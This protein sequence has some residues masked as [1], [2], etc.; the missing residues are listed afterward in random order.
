MP[1]KYSVLSVTTLGSLMAAIDST[2]VFLAIPA[3]GRFFGAGVSF[4]SLVVVA[5]LVT[6]T[7]TMIPGGNLAT[8]YGKKS[9]YML[10]FALFTLSSALIAA[11]PD[12]LFVIAFRAL[13]GVGAGLLSTSTIPILLDVFPPGERGRAVGINSVS[14]AVG[15]LAGPVL[16]GLLVSFDWR[17]IFL[18]NVPIGLFA[19][20]AGYSRIPRDE[21]KPGVDVDLYSM[22]GLLIFLVPLIMGIS[23]LY[24]PWLFFALAA[25]PV[26]LVVEHRRPLIPRALIRNARYD[27]IMCA[28]T[29][30][31][32]AFFGTTYSLSVYLQD[33]LGVKPLLAGLLLA[34]YPVASLLANPLGG[35]L[36][37]RTRRGAA[38]M[39]GG[40]LLQGGSLAALAFQLTRF[41]YMSALLF[42]AGFGGSLYWAS[43]ST[44]AIDASGGEHRS[45][46]SGALFTVRNIALIISISAFPVFMAATSPGVLLLH[47]NIHIQ[48]AVM[49]YLLT[50]GTLSC[51]SA[52][53]MLPYRMAP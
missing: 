8:K 20:A 25:L 34:S 2:V 46:A 49:Y 27:Y 17:Y 4:L 32:M 7:S 5:Y 42:L 47:A 18:I 45:L 23:F 10:G 44:L 11:S 16:G 12:I 38:I 30:Q 13:E 48:D 1:G 37:D 33:D 6:S 41:D 21:G 9:F 29:L 51:L 26:F 43:S 15:A 50:A 35:Y 19:L 39:A 14:W 22:A 24:L 31:A 53:F 40:L 36:L 52:A 28:S 3:M